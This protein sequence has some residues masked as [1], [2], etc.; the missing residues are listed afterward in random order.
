MVLPALD[1]TL[2]RAFV[3]VAEDLGFTA[4]GARL[5]ATQSA[6]SLQIRKLED[7]LG[8]RLFDR[9]PQSVRLTRFGADFLVDA[10]AILAAHDGVARRLVPGTQPATV[11]MTISDH[12]AGN[13]L[14]DIL[15]HLARRHPDVLIEVTVRLSAEI[16]AEPGHADVTVLRRLAPGQRGES[17]FVDRLV[18]LAAPDLDWR[19]GE[20]VPLVAL[21]G[22]CQVRAAALSALASAG[23]AYR[24]IFRGAGV[25][26]IQAAVAAGLGVA[27]LDRRNVPAGARLIGTESGLPPLPDSEFLV[28]WRRK[29]PGDGQFAASLAAAFGATAAGS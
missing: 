26:A 11:A 21:A 18:W 10:R 15:G 1:I 20:P 23:L 19:P 22:A 17:L 27:C 3:A 25:A 9:S 24:E 29:P 2:L 16:E 8:R 13:R 6:V 4:A 12:A 28:D 7:R 14:P 5:G